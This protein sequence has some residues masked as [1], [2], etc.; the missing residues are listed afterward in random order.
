MK[1]TYSIWQNSNLLSV[2]NTASNAAEILAVMEDLKK[3]GG[4]FDYTVRKV[5]AN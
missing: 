4:G 3:L 1:I 2:S 5:E